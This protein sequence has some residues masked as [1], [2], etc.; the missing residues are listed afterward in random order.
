MKSKRDYINC[1]CIVGIMYIQVHYTFAGVKKTM[2]P[3]LPLRRQMMTSQ[4]NLYDHLTSRTP[5]PLQT[6]PY[7]PYRSHNQIMSKPGFYAYPPAPHLKQESFDALRTPSS[8]E[9][10]M[11]TDNDIFTVPHVKEEPAVQEHQVGIHEH[12]QRTTEQLWRT[13][14]ENLQRYKQHRQRT[15]EYMQRTQGEQRTHEHMQRT[16]GEQ[17]THE[18]MQRTQD[19]QRTYEHLQSRLEHMKIGQGMHAGCSQETVGRK[20]TDCDVPSIKESEK[21]TMINGNHLLGKVRRG[22]T[23]YTRC[24]H[25]AEYGAQRKRKETEVILLSDSE[26][27]DDVKGSAEESSA[28][29]SEFTQ[30]QGGMNQDIFNKNKT[31]SKSFKC[32]VCH[33]VFDK[34]IALR[35]HHRVDHTKFLCT[36]CKKTYG[37]ANTLQRHMKQHSGVKPYECDECGKRFLDTSALKEH[38]RIHSGEKPHACDECGKIFRQSR[39]LTVHRRQHTGEMPFVCTE[40]G[41]KFR[42]ANGLVSHVRTKH[43][44]EKPYKCEYP[45]CGLSFAR[46]SQLR[47]HKMNHTGE[48]PHTCG[49][50]SKG[51]KTRGDYKRH[52]ERCNKQNESTGLQRPF[53]EANS[54]AGGKSLES[55]PPSTS[56]QDSGSSDTFNSQAKESTPQGLVFKFYR[57]NACGHIFTKHDL[58]TS[59]CSTCTRR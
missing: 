33:Q 58:Y 37:T 5:V 59:H 16:Q 9:D 1:F 43:T 35:L 8:S 25:K 24:G 57:C 4:P 17:R 20:V 51:F 23:K 13:Y 47:L 26:Q 39:H 40:C 46:G 2:P 28:S 55:M 36:I 53:K 45:Q 6:Y 12:W 31:K 29:D 22:E 38:R 11:E 44:G 41:M 34:L 18:H 3:Q 32:Q 10:E 19:E 15:H 50:C 21:T 48:R 7:T 27:E 49:I 14:D 52:Y 30:C 42:N 54:H 56:K